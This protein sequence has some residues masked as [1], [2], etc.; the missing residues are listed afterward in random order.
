MIARAQMGPGDLMCA[1]DPISGIYT[2][3]APVERPRRR[4][5][6]DASITRQSLHKQR[7]M[8]FPSSLDVTQ[9]APLEAILTSSTTGLGDAV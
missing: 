6:R 2:D 7:S 8:P 3:E 5:L 4:L 1:S 9:W